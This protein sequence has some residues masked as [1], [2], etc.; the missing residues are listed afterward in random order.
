M[1]ILQSLLV[2]ANI[3]GIVTWYILIEIEVDQPIFVEKHLNQISLQLT[4]LQ[5]ILGMIVVGSGFIGYLGYKE[6]KANA[7]ELAKEAVDH[8]MKTPDV[9]DKIEILIRE[10]RD[11]ISAKRS[12]LGEDIQ[13]LVNSK[14]TNKVEAGNDE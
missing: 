13:N 11:E 2:V 5:I 3:V 1:K 7:D 12:L 14:I 4:I 10:K 6:L 9:Q 8:Y